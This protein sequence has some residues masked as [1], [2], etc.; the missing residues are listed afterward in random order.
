MPEALDKFLASGV[1]AERR[2]G[3]IAAG[4]F[5][6]LD[7]LTAALAGETDRGAWEFGVSVLRHWLGRAA[8]QDAALLK[9]LTGPAGYTPAQAETAVLLLH[10]FAP[11]D[12]DRPETYEVL[13]EYLQADRPL[14]RN[15]AAWHLA[16][17]V[18]AGKAIPFRPN[19]GKAAVAES[20]AAWKALVPAGKLPP[21]EGRPAPGGSP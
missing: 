8:G 20:Y 10:G 18:P 12:R 5:D 3:L 4:A 11:D 16:R 19:A 1:P 13:I 9:F 2:V 14:V 6:D 7:R 15:L 17:L 21:K